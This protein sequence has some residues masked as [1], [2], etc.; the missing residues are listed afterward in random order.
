MNMKK[1]L[2]KTA[3]VLTLVGGLNWGLAIFNWN[4]VEG[5]ASVTAPVVAPIVYGLVAVSA[6]VVVGPAILK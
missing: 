3:E 1:G 4:L 2:M 6:V 5:L